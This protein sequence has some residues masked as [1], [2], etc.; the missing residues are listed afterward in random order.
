MNRQKQQEIRGFPGWLEICMGIIGGGT[1]AQE[2]IAELLRARL[3]WANVCAEEE[4]QEAGHQAGLSESREK[5]SKPSSR[6]RWANWGRSWRGTWKTDRLID[7]TVYRLYALTE[8]EVRIV[9][10]TKSN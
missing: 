2:Q 1:H 6:D 4:R 7:A 5:T 10:G 8:E 3:P 9:G